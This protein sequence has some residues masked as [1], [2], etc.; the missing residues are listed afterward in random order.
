MSLWLLLLD[1]VRLHLPVEIVG[2][3]VLQRQ[4]I[5]THGFPAIDDF[6]GGES[7]FGFRLVEDERLGADLEGL[8]HVTGRGR[9]GEK[10]GE[11]VR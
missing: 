2:P 5:E 3:L 7:G 11:E 10:E 8:L 4:E 1:P 6:L 9:G